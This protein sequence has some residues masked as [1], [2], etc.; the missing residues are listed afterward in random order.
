MEIW[1]RKDLA[2]FEWTKVFIYFNVFCYIFSFEFI[3]NQTSVTS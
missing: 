1:D 3:L 2:I